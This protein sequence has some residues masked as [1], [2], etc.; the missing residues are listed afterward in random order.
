MYNMDMY[1]SEIQQVALFEA[2]TFP[3]LLSQIKMN[4]YIQTYHIMILQ[5]LSGFSESLSAV[6]IFE[7]LKRV[8]S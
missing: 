1:V 4:M 8:T 2:N 7:L 5:I 3:V 6:V